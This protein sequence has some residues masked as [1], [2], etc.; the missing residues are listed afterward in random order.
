[1]KLGWKNIVHD[2]VRFFVTTT[3]I[4]FAV[5]LM[6]FQGSLLVGFLRAASKLV[7]ATDTDLWITA[8]GV[9]CFDFA[10]TLPRRF[11]EIARG[12]EGVASAS[13]IA[14]AFAEYRTA[15]G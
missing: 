15:S 1:M 9:V 10:G 2:R 12:M 14:T 3:G 4:G 11:V 8:R 5:F 13:R 7:D 6:V